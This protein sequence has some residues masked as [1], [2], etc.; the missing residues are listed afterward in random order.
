MLVSRSRLC[1]ASDEL[2]RSDMFVVGLGWPS[3][4]VMSGDGE[5]KF[6][7]WVGKVV[8]FLLWYEHHH[9]VSRWPLFVGIRRRRKGLR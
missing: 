1:F 5:S 2:F 6:G 4:S 7:T 9:V 3:S 8:I